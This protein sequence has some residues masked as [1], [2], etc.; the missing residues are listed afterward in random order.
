MF[1]SK[2]NITLQ[3]CINYLQ[4]GA[5]VAM[6]KYFSDYINYVIKALED[7]STDLESLKQEMLL[8]ISFMQHERLIHFM[9]TC[10]FALLLF[11]SLIIFFMTNIMGILA[12]SLLMLLLLIPYIAHYFF[13]EN[14][15]QKLYKL[16]DE[17][18]AGSLK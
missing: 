15:V 4:N 10:L 16:Y 5:P 14:G 3:C 13:L 12:V 18:C 17:A 2:A 11:L 9:V 6:R 8:K 1:T 7:E